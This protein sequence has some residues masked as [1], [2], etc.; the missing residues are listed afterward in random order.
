MF[1]TFE[2]SLKLSVSLLN[3][4]FSLF[5]KRI[6]DQSHQ[7]LLGHASTAISRTHSVEIRDVA[8]D[9]QCQHVR[10]ARVV[11]AVQQRGSTEHLHKLPAAR[12]VFVEGRGCR[13]EPE[14]S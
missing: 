1:F 4:V 13:E 10:A 9:W 3:V 5:S 8:A 2:M 7:V 12:E 11:K 14:G 6:D